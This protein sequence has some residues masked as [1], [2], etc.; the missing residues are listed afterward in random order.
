MNGN[1]TLG[2][3]DGHATLKSHLDTSAVP[4][5]AVEHAP[6]GK[7]DVVSAIRGNRLSQAA[8][9]M[10]VMVK[11][12]KNDRR[13]VNAVVP[14]NCNLDF[15]A[16][17]KLFGGDRVLMAPIDRA[18]IFTGC[19]MGAV[20]PFSFHPELTLVVDPRLVEEDEIVF[21]AGRLDMSFFV[22]ASDYIKAA[23]PKLAQIGSKP[24]SDE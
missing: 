23:N 17:A 12:G 18:Q 14:G 11:I 16:I 1:S 4:Y 6:E 2:G 3:F 5:R 8:K 15:S 22:N 24:L 20:T 21:N 13:Y 7:T 10:V 9:A 19:P